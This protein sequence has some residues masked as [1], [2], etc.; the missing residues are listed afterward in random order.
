MSDIF[1]LNFDAL[2]SPSISLNIAEAAQ[3]RHPLGWG[4][5]WYPNDYQGAAVAKDPGA[6]NTKILTEALMDW[7]NFRSTT[8]ISKIL[9]AAQGYTNHETQPF[10]R[11][12]AGRDWV[13]MHNGDLDKMSLYK[14]H[15]NKSRFLEPLGTTD[16]EI[17]FC[18]LL[19]MMQASGARKLADIKP[20]QL[21]A[22]FTE[23]DKLGSADMVI[24]DGLTLVCFQGSQSPSPIY[25]TRIKPKTKTKMFFSDQVSLE[26]NDPRDSYRTAVIFSSSKFKQGEWQQMQPGQIIVAKRGAVVWNNKADASEKSPVYQGL[27]PSAEQK[28][29]TNVHRPAQQL[30]TNQSAVIQDLNPLPHIASITNIRAMTH[31]NEGEP[32][33]YRVFDV[34]HIS[35]YEYTEAVEHSTHRFRLQPLED[36]V[37]DVVLSKLTVSV[38]GE[39]IYYEDVFGNQSV[40]YSIDLPYK[41]LCIEA[42][43][44]VK[45]YASPPDDYNIASR[46]TS[47]PLVWM[48]WQRQMMMS[49]LLPEELPE[50][51][52]S[53]L[54]DYAMSFAERNEYHLINTLE[55]M[56]QTIYKDYDYIQ[57]STSLS[58]TPFEVYASRQGVCQDFANL[59]ICLCR[60]LSIPAR[61]RMGYI[62]TG[63]NYENK[64]QSEASHAWAEVYLPY[65]GWRGF[66]PTN[67]CKVSQDHIRVACGRNYRDATPTSGTIFRG[68]GLETLKV[69]VKIKE[70]FDEL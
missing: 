18:Y 5:A 36:K 55:D 34:S 22:W 41:A 1:A 56:N 4:F 9:G 53:E 47:M 20:E 69:E 40:H 10:S 63:A 7:E 35:S 57:G 38:E 37:Q 58:T 50:T 31:T 64:L 28:D 44:R 51:Q 48:P 27:E 8:F 12:F 66:D 65:M 15:A 26:I 29:F 52:L 62:Y 30:Q 67:G 45:L 39:E 21:E 61:Y 19:G 6:K 14:L 25:Y 46:K 33:T 42:T 68:G 16:S 32:L 13:F 43:S 11:S 59:F 24:T 23:L 70:V 60:L 54:T 3:G 17:A 49:Y 2:S